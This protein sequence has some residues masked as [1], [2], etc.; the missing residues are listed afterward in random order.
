MINIS[1]Y[2]AQNS[3]KTKEKQGSIQRDSGFNNH[4]ISEGYV[5]FNILYPC[6][7]PLYLKPS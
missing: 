1:E 2:L 6:I 3:Q 4:L 7:D 5:W